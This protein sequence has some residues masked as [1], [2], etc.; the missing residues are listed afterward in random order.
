MKRILLFA[1]CCIT[2]LSAYAQEAKYEWAHSFGNNLY[3]NGYAVTVDRDG[4]V[5]TTGSFNKMTDFDPSPR[6][7]AELTPNGNDDVY[8]CKYTGAGA[9]IWAKKMGGSGYDIGY[10]IKVDTSGNVCVTGSFQN[11]PDF[12]PGDLVFNLT[13]NGGTD[14]FV[15][16]LNKAGEFLWAKQIGNSGDE[17]GRSIALDV[18]GNMFVTGSFKSAKLDFNPGINEHNLDGK[19]N[20]DIFVVK[21]TTSGGFIWANTIG[22]AYE[23]VAESIAPDG[24]GGVC[25]T[26]YFNSTVDF[27]PSGNVLNLTSPNSNTDIFIL[28]LS[29]AGGFLWAKNI[30]SNY[31]DKGKAITADANGN[32]Y[33]TGTFNGL[34]DFDPNAGKYELNYNGDLDVFV[35]KLDKL[36]NF[37]WAKNLGGLKNDRGYSIALDKAGNVYTTGD[38]NATADFDP[39]DRKYELTSNGETDI[40]ISKLDPK[41]NSIWAK[42][43]GGVSYDLGKSI[44]VDSN[45]NIYTTGV[46]RETVDFDFAPSNTA[47]LAFAG[48]DDIFLLKMAPA[49]LGL[50][51]RLYD[52]GVSL[53]PNPTEGSFT[54]EMT[55]PVSQAAIEIYNSV[56]VLVYSQVAVSV[57]NNLDISSLSKGLYWVRVSSSEGVI[58]AQELVK[59]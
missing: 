23:E 5:Y 48:G 1:S 10:A 37:V 2:A 12:D 36:G 6:G 34:A 27:D 22:S 19:G 53:Y 3:D 21:L 33:T 9:L 32:I 20:A 26:G 31:A 28:R 30:G 45:G 11:M 4:N 42:S 24:L 46:Y 40:F 39:S 43:L 29:S 52:N 7:K 59:E 25:I 47:S 16:K 15:A 49:T 35:S 54:L 38:F 8:I 13:S 57:G 41:G 55:K 56:G 17:E 58:A 14:I 18:A 50:E 44:A 51:D